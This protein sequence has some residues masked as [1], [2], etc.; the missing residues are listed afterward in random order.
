MLNI[1]LLNIIGFPGG[2]NSEDSDLGSV[3]GL[4]RFPGERSGNPLQCSFLEKAR[5]QRSLA[6]H[7]PRGCKRQTRLS[8]CHSRMRSFSLKSR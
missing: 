1:M 5:G 6:G 4:R 7:G 2:S 8:D 3:P